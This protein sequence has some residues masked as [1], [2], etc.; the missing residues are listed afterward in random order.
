MST[1]FHRGVAYRNW[2]SGVIPGVAAVF[3]RWIATVWL[4]PSVKVFPRWWHQTGS[5]LSLHILTSDT[6]IDVSEP[7]STL[8]FY[9]IIWWAMI[10]EIAKICDQLYSGPATILQRWWL[11]SNVWNCPRLSNSTLLQDSGLWPLA[12]VFPEEATWWWC[13]QGI[14]KSSFWYTLLYNEIGNEIPCNYLSPKQ[15]T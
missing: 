10:R 9:E 6:G 14:A 15:L 8:W 2:Y 11:F 7:S 4:A 5:S 13:T 1:V 12:N 3:S